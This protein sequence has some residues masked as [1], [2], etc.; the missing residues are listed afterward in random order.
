MQS[1]DI[2]ALLVSMRMLDDGQPADRAMWK[3]WETAMTL[4]HAKD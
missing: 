1:D 4:L 3:E 2:G